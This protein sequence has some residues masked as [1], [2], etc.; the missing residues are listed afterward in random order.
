MK[1]IIILG[2]IL[3][4]FSC[5]SQDGIYEEYIVPNGLAYPVPAKNA[6][7]KPGNGRI[8]IAWQNS[9][10]PKVEKARIFWN[11]YTDSVEVTINTD[12]KTVSRIIGPIAENTYSFMVR[13]Y[14]DKGNVSIPI[15]VMGTVYGETYLSTLSNRRLINTYYDGLDLKLNWLGVG[16]E[17]ETGISVNYTDIHGANRNV[18]VDP[19][20]TETLIPE[21]DPDQLLSYST[22][23]KPNSLAIDVFHAETVNRMI[24]PVIYIPKNTWMEYILPGDAVPIMDKP[25]YQLQNI[26]NDNFS[27]DGDGTYATQSLPLPLWANWD[28]GVT[29]KLSRFKLWPRD[30]DDDR[31]KGGHPKVFEIYG[32]N[33]PNPNGALD[34]SWIP[35]GRFECVKPSGPGPTVT[36]EDTDFAKAG[37]DFNFVANDF[38]PNPS[39]PVRYIRLRVL[40]IFSDADP[41]VVIIGE[42]SLWGRLVR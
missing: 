13:T 4:F 37:I 25:Y 19:S 9:A 36:Q 8:E 11:N 12:M 28:M 20:E 14:D 22:M 15:E 40:S 6:V 41:A 17:E 31:W 35:L 1:K 7:A 24:D 2:I 3:G 39:V 23:Y 10:D 16:K 5:K 26:W 34:E 18:V 21:F 27:Y 29:A 33:A 38:A 32:S 30:L 42:I